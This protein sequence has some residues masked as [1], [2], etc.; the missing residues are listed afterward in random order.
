MAEAPLRDSALDLSHQFK[1][2]VIDI[3]VVA[4][5]PLYSELRTGTARLGYYL[6]VLL[7]GRHFI[8]VPE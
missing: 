5:K 3:K 7:V 6:L 4:G 8:V 2:I 1:Q